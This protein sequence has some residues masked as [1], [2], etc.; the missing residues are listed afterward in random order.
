MIN[1]TQADEELEPLKI[2]MFGEFTIENSNYVMTTSK[3]SGLTS[4]LLT[5]YLIANR[6]TD[7]TSDSLI[8][9]LWPEGNINNP[10]GALRTLC[11]R[12]RKLLSKFYPGKD[13]ELLVRVN[14]IYS[15]NTDILQDIDIYQFEHLC[16]EAF[17]EPDPAR[18]YA[19]LSQSF[20]LYKGEFL[21]LFANQSWVLFRSNYYGNLYIKCV[22]KMCYFL[23]CQGHYY[24]T[25]SLC[26]KAL[27]LAPSTDESLHKQKLYA[28]LK[29]QKVQE[30][31]DYYYSILT[32]FSQK[33]GLDITDSMQDIYQEILGHMPNQYQ[34]L[35]SLEQNLKK[36]ETQ[37][38][39]FYCNF[40]IFQNI[41]QVN[42]RSVRRSQSRHY[43]ILLTFSATDNGSLIS[44]EMKE[45]MDILQQVMEKRLRSN[46]VYTKSSICQF[47]LIIAVP[48]ENG[49]NVVIR[50]LEETYSKKC[51][52]PNII[53]TIESSEIH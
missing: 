5:A 31:L 33:Y 19:L 50:R 27:E 20:E 39:S 32:L 48:N 24:E 3:K 6:G 52:H 53:L 44:N 46:D 16:H 15:W 41:Y 23:N 21:P 51:Q 7:I 25:L 2:H 14:N 34:T 8:D 17:R 12:T 10:A 49:R 9:V 29:L 37:P 42:L 28:L 43:L 4:F 26:N 18:Q 47:S 45:E 30:A 11:Y 38:G 1:Q 35:A 40:D 36:K 22:N 13:V